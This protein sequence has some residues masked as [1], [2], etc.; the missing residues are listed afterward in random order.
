MMLFMEWFLM[1]NDVIRIVL[2]DL[3]L[4]F[5][6]FYDIIYFNISNICVCFYKLC[7]IVFCKLEIYKYFILYCMI[8]E[9]EFYIYMFFVYVLNLY[10]IIV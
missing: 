6:M 7:W 3:K 9:E 5:S 8:N 10:L 2:L 1:W 4:V